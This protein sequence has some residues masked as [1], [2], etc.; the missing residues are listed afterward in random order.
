MWKNWK[1]D[2]TWSLPPLPL[3]QTVTLSQ[4]PSPLWSVTYFMDGPQV[5]RHVLHST[6][7]FCAHGLTLTSIR[8]QF[9]EILWDNSNNASDIT[10]GFYFVGT[11]L[12]MMHAQCSL[13]WDRDFV[14]PGFSQPRLNQNPELMPGVGYWSRISILFLVWVLVPFSSVEP[15]EFG[16]G[17]VWYIHSIIGP[18]DDHRDT[19]VP[20]HILL[21]SDTTTN[22]KK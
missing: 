9:G 6:P 2:V 13:D 1:C 14:T 15:I 16:G 12:I 5:R 19:G 8:G 11:V 18:L 10:I 22:S 4:T 17:G 21:S 3:S 20:Y 7:V